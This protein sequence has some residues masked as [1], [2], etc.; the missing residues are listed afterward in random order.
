[1]ESTASYSKNRGIILLISLAGVSIYLLPYFKGYYYDAYLSYFGINDMQ[2]ATFG[3]A[4]GAFTLI[5]YCFGGWV[6]DNLPLKI[7]I[8]GS[9][10]VTGAAGLILLLKPPYPIHVA[11]YALWGVSTVLTFW[12][13]MMKALRALSKPEEQARSYGLFDIGRGALNLI[14]GGGV[15]GL[16][17]KLCT[18][19]GDE[20]GMSALIVFYCAEVIIV[21]VIISIVL[22]RKLPD[23]R[24]QKTKDSGIKDNNVIFGKE[25][26]K[27]LKMPI[28]W[29]LIV[30]IGTT[31]GIQVSYSYIVPYCTAA[32]GM[33]AALASIMGY[34]GSAFRMAGCFVGG[35]LAD[36][37]GLSK[38]M[39]I[40]MFVMIGGIIG[41]LLTPQSMKYI[42]MLI[43]S[44]AIMAMAMY[45]AY[46]LHYAMFEEGN[47]PVES[48]G[49]AMFII[50][51]IA[52]TSEVFMPLFDGWCLSN[53]EG[54]EGYRVMFIGFIVVLIV[55]II[56]CLGFRALSKEHRKELDIMRKSKNDTAKKSE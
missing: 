6:A 26:L 21:G 23:L 43:V 44:V 37:I 10:I 25:I 3:S 22:S 27:V 46:A 2:M 15:V 45:S 55:G 47:Y 7:V 4:F 11:I 50:T 8:P 53:Y 48:M 33:S 32:F 9:M 28:S 30:I 49:A 16:F 39:L 29:C 51:P 54:V 24:N 36:K 12:N 18:I 13:P 1:M 41:I 31:Y 38:M 35:H 19:I 5:G 52:F 40:D 20:K 56:A 17:T 42:F 14:I 34:A